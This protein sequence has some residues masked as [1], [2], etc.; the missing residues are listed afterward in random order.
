MMRTPLL[1]RRSNGLA[2]RL[3]GL[4]GACALAACSSAGARA[5]D[6]PPRAIAVSLHG[7]GA[8]PFELVSAGHT[9]PVDLYS[10]ERSTASTKV[11]EDAVMAAL[12][13]H[14][15]DLGFDRYAHAG[16]APRGP[17]AGGAFAKAIEVQDGAASA[18]WA[19]TPAAG[20]DEIAAFGSAMSAF[21][22]L[23]NLT[24]GWQS[25]DNESGSEYFDRRK[26][27]SV[28]R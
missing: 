16:T 8:A 1:P 2:R 17:D 10:E 19:L 22:Q 18:W 25:V 12:V 11:Q 23:Y 21:L 3:S 26:Q 28:E 15:D 4:L 7:V 5:A 24:Q 20:K 14:L 27:Q 13:E 6:A 9:R